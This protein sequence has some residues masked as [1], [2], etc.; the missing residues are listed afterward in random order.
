[1]TKIEMLKELDKLAQQANSLWNQIE[2][3]KMRI[4]EEAGIQQ[5]KLKANGIYVPQSRREG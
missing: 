5:S 1:M 4:A 2:S 3:I